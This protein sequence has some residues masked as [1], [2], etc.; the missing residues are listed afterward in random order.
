M[1]ARRSG[2]YPDFIGQCARSSGVLALHRPNTIPRPMDSD[3]ASALQ[4]FLDEVEE[5]LTRAQGTTIE[6]ESRP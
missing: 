5:N 6:L 2:D 1:Q 4:V 3:R